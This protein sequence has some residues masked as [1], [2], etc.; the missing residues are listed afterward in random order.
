[1]V[2]SAASW[3]AAFVFAA[4]MV[5][6]GVGYAKRS[7]T[8]VPTPRPTS[9]LTVSQTNV[10]CSQRPAA[11]HPPSQRRVSEPTTRGRASSPLQLVLGSRRGI[12]QDFRAGARRAA[13]STLLVFIEDAVTPDSTRHAVE[14]SVAD[15]KARATTVVG[16]GLIR[17]AT[18]PA[19]VIDF[20]LPRFHMRRAARRGCP[21]RGEGSAREPAV[22]TPCAPCRG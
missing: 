5:P 17:C 3:P 2:S 11:L 21:A 20:G 16:A 4:V 9:E 7:A 22:R 14:R 18:N 8:N 10:Q 13:A 19:A 12:L 1:M 15:S 6:L